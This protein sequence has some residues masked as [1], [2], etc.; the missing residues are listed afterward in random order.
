MKENSGKKDKKPKPPKGKTL[1]EKV[2]R[3][4]TDEDD[5]ITEQ[6]LKEVI[7]GVEA[8]DLKDP[9]EPTIL[10]DDIPPKK[11]ITPWDVVD[12]KE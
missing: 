2:H 12:D 5:I 11:I 9:E 4:L 7:V 3:H 8:V 1:K 10:A 6:D